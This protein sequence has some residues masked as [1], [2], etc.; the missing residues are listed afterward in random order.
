MKLLLVSLAAAAWAASGHVNTF[1]I[2]VC[3]NP[4]S[5]A[6]AVTQGQG[7]ASQILGSAGV[8]IAWRRDIRSCS[9]A[10]RAIVITLSHNAPADLHPDELAYALP[11]EHTRIVVFWDR[12]L[13][14]GGPA[15]T[16]SLLGH[17]LAHEIVHMLQGIERHSTS[18]LM[19]AKWDHGDYV[20]MQRRTLQMTDEDIT[21]I[22]R[23]IAR[24][25]AVGR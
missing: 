2:T 25:Q 19:K 3:L 5:N 7:A 12:V 14:A 24:R 20:E 21:L 15:G 13:R 11:Y 1:E 18:G 22:E 6:I 8:K 23:G 4:Q 17:V 10:E 16:S 9:S